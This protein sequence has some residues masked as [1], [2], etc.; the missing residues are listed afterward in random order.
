[1]TAEVRFRVTGMTCA[2]CA[3]RVERAIRKLEGVA[4]ASVNLAT[5]DAVARFD[6]ARASAER[7]FAAVRSAGYGVE[8]SG[9]ALSPGREDEDRASWR[10]DLVLAAALTAPLF[11]FTMGSMAGLPVPHAPP[12]LELLLATP[13]VFGAGFRFHRL[14]LAELRHLG[15]GMNTLVMLGSSAAWAYSSLVVAA[16]GVFPAGTAHLYFEAAAA[17]VTLV[18]LGRYLEAG[19][20]GRTSEAIR[21]LMRLEPPVAR[22]VRDGAVAEV[23]VGEVRPGD[24][25]RVHPGERMPVDGIV[26]EGT[27]HVDE[28]M[29]TGE[30][31]PV[32]KRPGSEVVGGTVNGNGALTLRTTRT[33]ADTVLARIVRMVRE[34]Q[35]SKPP[36]QMLADRIAGFFVPAVIAVAAVTFAAWM[37]AGPAP[38]LNHA[39]VAA[40]SVLLIACPCAMGLATPTAVMVATGRAADLGILVR[41][42]AALE[43]L[44]RAD[45]V[46]FDKT[47]TLTRGKPELAGVTAIGMSEAELVG[48]AASA[49]SASEHPIARA[50]VAG[51][52]ARGIP[53]RP[54]RDARAVPGFGLEAEV[55]GRRVNVG[56]RRYLE[57]LGVDVSAAGARKSSAYAAVDGGLSGTLAVSDPL[58]DESPAVVA[59]IRGRGLRVAMLTGDGEE[60]AAAAAREAGIGEF[61]AGLSPEGKAEEIGRMQAAGRKVVFVGDGINDAPAL[62]RADAGVAIGTGTDIAIEAGD[63]VLMGGDVRGVVTAVALARRT[64]RTI[65]FNFLWA[66]GYNV[67][68]V[69]VAA[70]ALFPLTGILLNPMLAAAAMSVS[71][72]FVVGNSL[73]LKRFR[74]PMPR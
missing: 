9:T 70:G 51:A 26:T 28:S 5:A 13:V 50:V 62:A 27:S 14:G 4:D 16:P 8:D 44:A 15:P 55:G 66:Y 68:L 64:L 54:A 71:S 35:T 46:V 57:G 41:R 33:G 21:K 45:T 42:G 30:P 60:T 34:A 23:P 43:A 31:M 49:E 53:L 47:G 72:L 25:V 38:A 24:V 63:V 18:L 61:M 37:A 74:E 32:A 29:I 17:I 20:R 58:K 73:L 39:F 22:I 52:A 69:P 65:G 11:L 3:A 19:A 6:P 48:L 7:V 67:A 10:R 40:V 56:S 59:A 2:N 1:M 12:W 36:V